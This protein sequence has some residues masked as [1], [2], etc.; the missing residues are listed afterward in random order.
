M[1]PAQHCLCAILGTVTSPYKLLVGITSYYLSSVFQIFRYSQSTCLSP[2]L[3][4]V[5]GTVHE[6]LH[7]DQE[8][9]CFT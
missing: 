7:K 2:S 5:C 6:S 3:A 9:I 4:E 8:F 1:H